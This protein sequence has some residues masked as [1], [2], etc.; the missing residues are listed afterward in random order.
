MI[1]AFNPA[2]P[3]G[4][5][6]MQVALDRNGEVVGAGNMR[7]QTRRVPLPSRSRGRNHRARGNS[8]RPF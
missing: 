3:F 1:G 5:F 2:G 6:S 8:A 4:A 7:A